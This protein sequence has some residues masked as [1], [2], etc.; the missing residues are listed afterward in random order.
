MASSVRPSCPPSDVSWPTM[1]PW[2]LT[3]VLQRP[4]LHVYWVEP[5]LGQGRRRAV[6]LVPRRLRCYPQAPSRHTSQARLFGGHECLPLPQG[7]LPQARSRPRC[8]QYRIENLPNRAGEYSGHPQGVPGPQG[9]QV[10]ITA[11]QS[12]AGWFGLKKK[13]STLTMHEGKCDL[14]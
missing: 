2:T 9:G 1:T 6:R 5:E 3:F 10:L 8:R 11:N 7:L 14:R 4:G 13:N 12:I